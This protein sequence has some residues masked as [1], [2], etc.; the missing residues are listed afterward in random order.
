MKK[1]CEKCGNS[2]STRAGNFEKHVNSCNGHYKKFEKAK[3]CKYCNLVFDVD[4]SASARANHTRWCVNNPKREKYL[5]TLQES[6]LKITIQSREQMKIGIKEAHMRGAYD[7]TYL[8]IV[9]SKTKNGTLKH[10]DATKKL[11]SEKRRNFLLNNPEKHP[12]RNK[13]KNISKPCEKIKQFLITNNFVFKEEF[14]P[15]TDRFFSI[16]IAFND[17]KLGIEINGNQHYADISAG[18]LTE[19]YQSRHDL[20]EQSGWRLLEIPYWYAFR[21]EDFIKILLNENYHYFRIL[22]NISIID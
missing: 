16:D 11:L 19:Y 22:D 4:L 8:K 2:F 9:K 13:N 1:N 15:L 7:D 14:Q 17:I 12:W 20:I 6:R 18:L 21:I 5:A 10:T 3:V